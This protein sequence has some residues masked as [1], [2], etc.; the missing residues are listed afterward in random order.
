MSLG[1]MPQNAIAGSYGNFVFNYVNC[2]IMFNAVAAPFY[3]PISNAQG[4]QFFHILSNTYYFTHLVSFL[5]FYF[6]Y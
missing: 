4:F 2:A 5:L 3:I 6:L 1:H